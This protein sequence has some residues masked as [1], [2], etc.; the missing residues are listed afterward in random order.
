M[1]ALSSLFMGKNQRNSVLEFWSVWRLSG[2]L[3]VL[4]SL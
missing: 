1:S 2:L 4:N 3:N